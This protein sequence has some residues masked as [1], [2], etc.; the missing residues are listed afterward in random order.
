MNQEHEQEV[1]KVFTRTCEILKLSGFSFRVMKRKAPVGAVRSYT[2]GYSRLDKKLVCIDVY[3]AKKR[4][5]KKMSSILG[6]MAHELAHFQKPPYRQRH[7]GK[8]INRIHYPKFYK[9]VTK[10]IERF[11][12]DPVLGEYY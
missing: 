4:E 9:Q 1:E 2:V 12:K 7:R 10:N 3:T 5:A 11:K 8:W 6:V